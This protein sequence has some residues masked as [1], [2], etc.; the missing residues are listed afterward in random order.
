MRNSEVLHAFNEQ[1]SE[2]RPYGLTAEYWVPHLMKKPDRHNE[3]EI[4]YLADGSLTYFFQGSKITIPEKSFTVFW[5]IV[6][7]QIIEYTGSSPY[8]VCTI[9]LTLF[10]EWRLPSMF[11]DR[12]L[13]GEIIIENSGKQSVFDDF[14]LQHW[15]ED[16]TANQGQ[17]ATLLEMQARLVRMADRII[18]HKESEH[19]Q[20]QTSEISQVERIAMYIAQN[21][22]RPINSADIGKEVGLHPDYANV[23]FKKT[24]GMSLNEYLI[25]ERISHAQRKLVS[26]DMSIAEILYDCGYNSISSFNAAFRKIN[27]CTPREFRKKYH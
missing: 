2:F 1:R 11:V 22:N 16:L 4:N 10:L 3:I 13:K 27:K 26:S 24:F 9:P 15:I 19:V 21:Y 5:G 12:V 18:A 23:V 6:P 25:Q 8:C 20:I 7:H 14:L 17:K